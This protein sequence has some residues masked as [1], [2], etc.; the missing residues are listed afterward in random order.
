[1]PVPDRSTRRPR[2]LL[3]DLTFESVLDAILDGTLHPGERLFEDDIAAWLG[4]SKTPVKEA[5]ARL[6]TQGLVD[7]PVQLVGGV[8][9]HPVQ[10]VQPAVGD[11]V[12]VHVDEAGQQRPVVHRH[13]AALGQLARERL[14]AEHATLLD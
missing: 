3:R 4:V 9:R 13:L 7:H 2:R 6:A 8:A 11:E 14:E 10:G 1:M 5:L 12:G